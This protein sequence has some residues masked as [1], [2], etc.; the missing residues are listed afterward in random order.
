V[1]RWN[2]QQY[3]YELARFAL[4]SPVVLRRVR[5]EVGLSSGRGGGFGIASSP[6]L[7]FWVLRFLLAAGADQKGAA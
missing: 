5:F 7:K 1:S 2:G 4:S 3:G 6:G